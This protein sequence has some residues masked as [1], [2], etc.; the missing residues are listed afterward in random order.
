MK[1]IWRIGI[2]FFL[3]ITVYAGTYVCLRATHVITHFSPVNEWDPEKGKTGHLV[4]VGSDGAEA[5][6]IDL[7]FTPARMLEQAYH[8]A[9][10]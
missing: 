10:D 4:S 3:V 5:Q 2:A 6:V 8:N 9:V 1:K 7:V